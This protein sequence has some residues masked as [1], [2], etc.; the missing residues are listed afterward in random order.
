MAKSRNSTPS[1]EGTNCAFI[2]ETDASTRN[3]SQMTSIDHDNDDNRRPTKES[4]MEYR[5]KA[6]AFFCG[7]TLDGARSHWGTVV[8]VPILVNIARLAAPYIICSE[9]FDTR[10]AHDRFA[11]DQVLRFEHS[12]RRYGWWWRLPTDDIDSSDLH[13]KRLA[14]DGIV[15]GGITMPW[16][17]S[18]IF[19]AF[20]V[21]NRRCDQ[22]S[23][24][25]ARN[26]NCDPTWMTLVLQRRGSCFYNI[27]VMVSADKTLRHLLRVVTAQL[28]LRSDEST[29]LVFWGMHDDGTT[30]LES[31]T[32]GASLHHCHPSPL[33]DM[34]MG[35]IW[36]LMETHQQMMH[37]HWTSLTYDPHD[38]TLMHQEYH[39]IWTGL[40][41]L[42]DKPHA[43]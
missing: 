13:T 2:R 14:C 22:K 27:D 1:R 15:F 16:Q 40:L 6:L 38:Q 7:V 34:R 3:S 31:A 37:D 32:G 35:D 42:V 10:H 12:L 23:E 29:R 19:E 4:L 41:C 26:D 21:W 8:D 17:Q 9:M 20:S 36:V 39:A 25:L 28:R 11:H 5:K 18:D 33:M 24:V 43:A 30:D